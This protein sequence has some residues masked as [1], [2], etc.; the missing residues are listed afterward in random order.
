MR[1]L[2]W[3]ALSSGSDIIPA[4]V[5]V[6]GQIF[7]KI[8]SSNKC[9]NIPTGTEECWSSRP[10]ITSDGEWSL[11]CPVFTAADVEAQQTSIQTDSN[12]L[13]V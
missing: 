13:L 4:I 9:C 7:N 10:A 6:A 12:G 11:E 5:Q 8:S 3:S 1:P 2:I